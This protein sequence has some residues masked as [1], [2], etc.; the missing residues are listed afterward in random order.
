MFKGGLD[1]ALFILDLI[2]AILGL[3]ENVTND[4]PKTYPKD[5]IKAAL[6]YAIIRQII[7]LIIWIGWT[8][9]CVK[10]ENSLEFY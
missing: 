10:Y 3:V 4:E 7:F 8:Y 9:S 2:A 1:V 5:F 6:G